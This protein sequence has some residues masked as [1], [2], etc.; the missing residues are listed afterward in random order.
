[1]KTLTPLAAFLFALLCSATAHADD[2]AW[3]RLKDH[4]TGWLSLDIRERTYAPADG[5]GPVVTLV[6]AVH[7]ANPIYYRRIQ[8][9]LDGFDV[10]LYEGV[11]PAGTS[12]ADDDALTTKQRIARSENR[13]RLVSILLEQAGRRDGA[14]P[15]TLDELADVLAESPRPS[16][17]LETARVDA[18]GN[19]LVYAPLPSG[20]GFVLMSLGADGE[21]GGRRA[22]ADLRLSDQKPLSDAELGLEPGLQER[23]A[24][25]F[26]LSFQLNEMDDTRPNWI[27]SDMTIDE[28]QRAFEEAGADGSMLFGMLD[29]SSG[30]GAVVGLVLGAVERLPGMAQRGK[31]MIME[32]L[33][34]GDASFDMMKDQLGDGTVKV[35]IDE[36]NQV[37]IDDLKGLLADTDADSVAIW[38]GAG[39]MPDMEE[40]L[41]D[42]LGYERTDDD[43]WNPSMR[44]NLDR[45]GISQSERVMLRASMRRQLEQARQAAES[46]E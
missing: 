28:L 14:Y 36:R 1:M 38:Y 16:A 39:H 12:D 24:K 13:V 40:R 41:L 43:R 5:E 35:L 44:L 3:I 37:V 17:W 22:R 29:G 15:A 23:L 10:V 25:T 20:E 45:A 9:R 27:N 18:W 42:Q 33:S 4:D 11:N 30:M 21:P 6:G 7:I 19:E 34:L 31:L 32:V 8:E 2:D 46:A 26:R